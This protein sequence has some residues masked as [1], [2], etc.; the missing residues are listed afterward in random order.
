M[1]HHM[2]A[3]IELRPEEARRKI[4]ATFRSAK[5]HYG[6][7][8]K[9]LGCSHGTLNRWLATLGVK[10]ACQELEKKAEEEGWH[11]GIHGGA[12]YHRDKA[13]AA[14]KRVISTAKT[15]KRKAKLA[16]ASKARP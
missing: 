7:T 12:Q 2:L 6:Q 10:Q 13:A 8:A 9:A 3:L 14:A 11:H 15:K 16:S 1:R 5:C 4:V